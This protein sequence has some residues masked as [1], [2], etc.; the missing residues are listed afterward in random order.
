M[1]RGAGVGGLDFGWNSDG[2]LPLLPADAA[3]ATRPGLT[4][5]VA[6]YGHDAGC[7]V[8]GGVVVRDARQ[9][10]LDGGYLFGDA[11]SDNLWLI[12]PTGDGRREPLI[13]SARLGRTSELDQRGRRMGPS[14]RRA[15][16]PASCCGSPGSGG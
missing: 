7:A 12:D 1:S 2:G 3:A 10:R 5:P 9:G 11:C 8:I 6:E 15:S 14:T 13:A 16:A 4:L